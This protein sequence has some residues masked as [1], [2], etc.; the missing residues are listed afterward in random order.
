MAI[1]DAGEALA[2]CQQ[3]PPPPAPVRFPNQGTKHNSALKIA[4]HAPVVVI[5][6]SESGP[7]TIYSNVHVATDVQVFR[8]GKNFRSGALPIQL[9]KGNVSY[10]GA[11]ADQVI[12]NARAH[13]LHTTLCF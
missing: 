4:Y 12:V 11:A 10:G 3:F 5:T 8:L 7:I 9:T 13:I 6:R 2:V 1:G